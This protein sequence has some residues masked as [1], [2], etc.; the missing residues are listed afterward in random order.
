MKSNVPQ[1]RPGCNAPLLYKDFS[2]KSSDVVNKNFT[3]AGLWKLESKYK[4]APGT[5]N[6]K[7]LV[8]YTADT[9]NKVRAS[10]MTSEVE[11]V[12]D[13]GA[14]IKAVLTPDIMN[15]MKASL[16]YSTRTGHKMDVMLHNENG[17]LKY[18]INHS[19][20]GLNLGSLLPVSSNGVM[21]IS[22]HEKL[23]HNA[24]DM[25]VS[26]RVAPHC[27]IGMGGRYDMTAMKRPMNTCPVNWSM[28]CHYQLGLYDMAIRANALKTYTTN[29]S[30][31]I[32]YNWRNTK[33]H[34]IVS[35]E[36]ECGPAMKETGCRAV[37]AF[38]ATCPFLTGNRLV[39]RIDRNMKWAVTYMT[40]MA[41]S[42]TMSVTLD[43]SLRAGV[44]L[45][46][47]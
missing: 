21:T 17:A 38:D 36:V 8:I 12:A 11:Y 27:E 19:K 3:K 47:E 43:K 20:T 9:A 13:C 46:R 33:Q 10:N 1:S 5:I 40:R 35:G 26:M 42:W 41:D 7:P 31:P 39:A 25:G 44:Q 29:V 28:G 23:T 14:T 22:T 32:T 24:L 45:T 18:E 4:S 30:T 15:N 37:V 16:A 2:K 34:V 6:V